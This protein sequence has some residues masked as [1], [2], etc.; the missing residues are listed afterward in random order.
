MQ[1]AEKD[2]AQ[3]NKGKGKRGRKPKNKKSM[4]DGEEDDDDDDGLAVTDQSS[5]KRKSAEGASSE[6][7]T[8]VARLSEASESASAIALGVRGSDIGGPAPVAWMS[9][10]QGPA[11]LAPV[12]E[13]LQLPQP[14]VLWMSRVQLRAEDE[15][16]G[17]DPM[18]SRRSR[19]QAT[20][21]YIIIRDLR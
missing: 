20:F 15:A 11:P 13:A 4:A 17:T 14:L 9:E 1:R 18:S 3:Q 12:T 6:P 7:N 5:R 10:A 16:Q 8:K 19:P 21:S 2:A